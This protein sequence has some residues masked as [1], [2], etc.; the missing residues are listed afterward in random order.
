MPKRAR[1]Q[2]NNPET[3]CRDVCVA[4]GEVQCVRFVDSRSAEDPA[5]LRIGQQSEEDW[6]DGVANMYTVELS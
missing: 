4:A 6:L 1:E 3:Q 2:V 5:I